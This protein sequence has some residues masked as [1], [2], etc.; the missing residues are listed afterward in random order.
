MNVIIMLQWKNRDSGGKIN[1][2]I[3]IESKTPS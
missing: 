1:K 3:V 2:K